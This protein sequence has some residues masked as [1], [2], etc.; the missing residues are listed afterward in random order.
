MS[1]GSSASSG[2]LPFALSEFETPL[3]R[4]LFVLF[5]GGV[6]FCC[7]LALA[8]TLLGFCLV[9]TVWELHRRGGVVLRRSPLDVPLLA[10][11]AG[12]FLSAVASVEPAVSFVAL[13]A[14][15]SFLL[16]PLTMARVRSRGAGNAILDGFAVVGAVLA[17]AGVVQF[18]NGMNDLEHRIRGPLHHYMTYAG[19]LLLLDLVTLARIGFGPGSRRAR[20]A[21]GLGIVAGAGLIALSVA[22]EI[23]RNTSLGLRALALILVG[24]VGLGARRTPELRRSFLLAVSAAAMTSAIALSYTRNAWI[25]LVVGSA[26]ILFAATPR[27]LLVFIPA[28][29]AALFFLPQPV[30]RRM[31]GT[32]SIRETSNY[33]RLCMIEAGIS[34][35]EDRP[36]FGLGLDAVKI[37]YPL[38]RRPDAPRFRVPHLHNNIIQI[39]AERG[40]FTLGAYLALLATFFVKAGGAIRRATSR[41]DK[42]HL[43]APLAAIAGITVAGLFESNFGDTEVLLATLFLLALPFADGSAAAGVTTPAPPGSKPE[44]F[45]ASP[46]VTS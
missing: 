41:D 24:L 42:K 20:G 40:L 21:I 36:L 10:Y 29:M 38:Y 46:A 43:V 45:G 6:I 16:V 18:A 12:S 11:V 22:P 25:G 2:P 31:A 39:G 19:F 35:I 33:D 44:P 3:S 27:A 14:F 34:M 28:V 32:F 5:A 30:I 1:S 37:R 17:L 8:N 15:F 26:V 13:K 23:G 7:R 4:S 9:G